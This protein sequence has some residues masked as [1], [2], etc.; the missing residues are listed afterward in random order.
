MN[1]ICVTAAL[2]MVAALSSGFVTAQACPEKNVQYWQAFTAGGESDMAARHQQAVLKKKCPKIETIV[3]YKPGAGGGLMWSQMNQLPGDGYN[4]VGINLP[5]IVLQP[6][7]GQVQYKTED[8]TPVYWFHYTP[9]AHRRARAESDQDLRRPRQNGE[10][11]ARASSPSAARAPTPRTTPR[12]S[13]S[14]S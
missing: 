8:I 2:A 4:I 5:H 6:L 1:R 7:E 9:D 12:T 14:K 13:G 3:Q 10:G 11:P